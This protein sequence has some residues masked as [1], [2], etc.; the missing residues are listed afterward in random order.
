MLSFERNFLNNNCR[1][2][3]KRFFARIQEFFNKVEKKTFFAKVTSNRFD[4]M[5]CMKLSAVCVSCLDEVDEVKYCRVF[6]PVSKGTKIIKVSQRN[7]TITV[8]NTLVSK[9]SSLLF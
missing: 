8:E 7:S 1:N 2:E 4:R 3:C 5:H 9:N 6:I